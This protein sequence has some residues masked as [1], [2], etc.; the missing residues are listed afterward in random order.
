MK[1]VWLVFLFLPALDAWA[2]SPVSRLWKEL[3][4]KRAGLVSAHQEFEVIT[5]YEHRGGTQASKR[6]VILDVSQGLWR[7]SSLG[8][9]GDRIRI[10]DGADTLCMEEDGD[11][12]VRIKGKSNSVTAPEPYDLD[13]DW[14]K[15]KEMSRQ[16]CGFD[17]RDHTCVVLQGPLKRT[18]EFNSDNHYATV[19]EGIAGVMLDLET[20]L[21]VQS[22][23]KQSVQDHYGSY[24]RDVTY[25]LKRFSMGTPVDIGLFKVPAGVHEVKQL[26][27]WNASRIR[28][29]LT[30]KPAP[31]LNVSDMKGNPI[32]LASFRGKTVLLDFWTSWCPPCRADAPALEKLN[33]KYG[34]DIVIVGISVD[35]DR[36]VVEK[37]LKEHMKSYPVVLTSENEMPRPYQMPAFPT[38][39]VI[40]QKGNITAAVDGEKGFGELRT[41][42][43]KAGITAPEP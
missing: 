35:E 34:K 38:Y 31:E 21:M 43:E 26:S 39:I 17:A 41:L 20:G 14:S 1:R 32:S 37:F 8:G 3:E 30:G 33:Q 24:I 16:P 11:E 27:L 28:K 6:M 19:T 9:S 7:R 36:A 10:F 15:A 18:T 25:S 22:Q 4:N 5:R 2:Q 40:D 29:Q 42:L 23:L 13:I 12:F